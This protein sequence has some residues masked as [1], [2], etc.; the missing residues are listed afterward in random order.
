MALHP[1]ITDIKPTGKCNILIYGDPSCGKT[2]LIAGGK[3]TLIVRPPT[4]HTDSV[5]ESDGKP[6]EWVV[7]SWDDMIAVE[8]FAR[9]NPAEFDWIWL[10]SISLFQD[11][12]LED[13][14]AQVE[15]AKP[16][17]KDGP[18]DQ[19]EY[20]NNF[21]RLAKWCRHMIGI[22]G[23]NFGITAHPAEVEDN[24]GNIKLRPWVQG[25]N[26]SFKI[27]GMMNV[28]AYMEVVT[29]K[30]E[31]RRVLRLKESDDYTAKDQ[32]DM[33]PDYRLVDPTMAKIEA[34]LASRRP[35]ASRPA[36]RTP[37]RKVRVK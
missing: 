1:A 11:H 29:A 4:D 24:L 36:R 15:A 8:E 31:E 25:K 32:F 33:T 28:V 9:H 23:F 26:M 16:H 2:R 34:A 35:S 18:I 7:E 27:C 17:R 19:G 6:K 37:K 14:M 30:E 12:G 22:P 5:R 13:I 3:R 10:D 21:V 20:N